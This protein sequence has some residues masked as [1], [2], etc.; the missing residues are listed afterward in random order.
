MLEPH[1]GQVAGA[2]HPSPSTGWCCAPGCRLTGYP[3]SLTVPVGPRIVPF[4]GEYMAVN[5]AKRDLV[6]GMIYPV[7]DLLYPFLGVHFTRRV[8]GQL[9]VGPNAG[10]AI[11]REG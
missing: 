11:R 9:E 8:S 5:R 7:P 1:R 6:R 3:N 4:R 10:L 2:R